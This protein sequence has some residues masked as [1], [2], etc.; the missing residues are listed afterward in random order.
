MVLGERG[1]H[2]VAGFG[3][4]VAPAMVLKSV[5]NGGDAFGREHRGAPFHFMNKTP[6]L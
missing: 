1:A 6:A 5:V 4:V 3:L 2:A